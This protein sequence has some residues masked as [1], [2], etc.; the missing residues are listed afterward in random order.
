MFWIVVLQKTFESPLNCKE[1]K[2]VNPKGNQLWIFI[3]KTDAEAKALI[4]WPPDV[5]SQFLGKDPDFGKGRGQERRA[6]EDEMVWLHHWLN[7][8]EF[9]QTPVD[10]EGQGAWCTSLH[11]VAKSQTQHHW[12]TRTADYVLIVGPAYVV[13]NGDKLRDK[14]STYYLWNFMISTNHWIWGA[15][16]SGKEQLQ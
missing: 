8:H 12:T 1:D 6:K 3:G 14:L 9:E 16:G 15:M 2:P 5:K 11:G 7:G 10:S 13:S 4:L